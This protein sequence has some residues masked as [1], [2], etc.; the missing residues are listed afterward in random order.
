MLRPLA[1]LAS[2]LVLTSGVQA[3][4]RSDCA[5]PQAQ[6]LFNELNALPAPVMIALTKRFP[7]LK[8]SMQVC[9]HRAAA[10]PLRGEPELCFYAGA[11]Y[12]SRWAVIVSVN[13]ERSARLPL[14]YRY[15]KGGDVLELSR[16][17]FGIPRC[18]LNWLAGIAPPPDRP[19][20]G[21]LP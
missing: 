15:E 5:L 21:R 17:E 7:T 12:G 9:R 18:A 11:Q 20:R 8:P 3:Q 19:A 1:I 6:Y 16:Q 14:V 10:S 13:G 4:V 2:S